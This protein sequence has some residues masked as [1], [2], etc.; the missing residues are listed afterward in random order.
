MI[1][2]A[3]IGAVG[4]GQGFKTGSSATTS[5]QAVA[6]VDD[7]LAKADKAASDALLAMTQAQAALDQITDSQGNININLFT[8]NFG[9]TAN[10]TGLLAPLIAKLQPLFDQVYDKVVLV[11]NQFSVARVALTDAIG[12]LNA[13]DPAQAAL[14]AKVKEQISRIDMLETTFRNKIHLL[15]GKM[16]LAITG[17]DRIVS[18]AT[19]FIPGFGW[20]ASWALDMFVMGDVKQLILDLQAKLLA[21]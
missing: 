9:A 11:K 17:L 4:C 1:S 7:Q 5:A 19:S 14:I 2:I 16:S 12:K 15:A 13:N 21:I 18:G 6:N 10:A 3:A 20:L 8:K